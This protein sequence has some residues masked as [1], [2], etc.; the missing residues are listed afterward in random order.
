M[1]NE[2]N[3]QKDFEKSD[4]EKA[5]IKAH[6]NDVLSGNYPYL[7]M[8]PESEETYIRAFLVGA[9]YGMDVS[10]GLLKKEEAPTVFLNPQD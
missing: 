1:N 4:Y 2:T 5:A 9:M 10:L 8:T 6:T 7:H 3:H